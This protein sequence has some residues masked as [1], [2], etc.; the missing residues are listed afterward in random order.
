MDLSIHKRILRGVMIM[1]SATLLA[2]VMYLPQSLASINIHLNTAVRDSASYPPVPSQSK[3]IL[4]SNT[5]YRFQFTLP[6]R[7]KGFKIITSSWKGMEITPKNQSKIVETG[8]YLSIRNPLWQQKH[9]RQDIPIYIFTLKQWNE[10]MKSIFSVSAAPIPPSEL[11]RNSKYIFALPARYNYSFLPGFQ[12]V[13][14]I[15][16]GKPLKTF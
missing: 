11:G 13:A 3:S 1:G 10:L 8:P 7:W 15:L 2:S 6:A 12:E 5:K 4:Y 9:P 14:K 16:A